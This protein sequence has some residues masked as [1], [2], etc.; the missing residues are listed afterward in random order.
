M[1]LRRWLSWAGVATLVA[2]AVLTGMRPAGPSGDDDRAVAIAESLRCPVCQG[3][4][5][6]DSDSETARAIR[7][8]IVRRIAEGQADGDIRQAYVE[9]YGEWILLRPRGGGLGTVVWLVP[10]AAVLLAGTAIA[11]VGRRRRRLWRLLATEQDRNVVAAARRSRRSGDGPNGRGATG[12]DRA[13]SR[14]GRVG[15]EVR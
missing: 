7:S 13:S 10:V 14:T 9:R 6:A 8:D 11:V 12:H 1:T 15:G 4:S 2:V 3:L 5:V